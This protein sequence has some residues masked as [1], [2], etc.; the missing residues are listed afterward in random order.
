MIDEVAM[1]PMNLHHVVATFLAL[2]AVSA[3]F[4][5]HSAISSLSMAWGTAN[6][7]PKRSEAIA[8]DETSCSPGSI[9][10]RVFCL[11]A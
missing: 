3:Y 8:E 2:M 7:I 11:P 5:I 1:G 9:V 6:L 4:S 10:D